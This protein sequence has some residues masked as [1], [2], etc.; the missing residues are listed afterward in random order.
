MKTNHK[1]LPILAA[2]LVTMFGALACEPVFAIGWEEALL[3]V[4]VLC[5]AFGPPLFRFMRRRMAARKEIFKD[6]K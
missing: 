3:L 1:H 2:G 6:R 5:L 4:G